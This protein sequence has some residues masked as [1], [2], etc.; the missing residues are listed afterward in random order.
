MIVGGLGIPVQQPRQH[1]PM[2]LGLMQ[3]LCERDIAYIM[4]REAS[5]ALAGTRQ[6]FSIMTSHKEVSLKALEIG[7]APR[8]TS[9]THFYPELEISQA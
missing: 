7:V 5:A 3:V 8:T 6:G 9:R 4:S 2:S 1:H